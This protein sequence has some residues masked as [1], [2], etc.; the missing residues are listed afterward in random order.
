MGWE[1]G[2]ENDRGLSQAPKTEGLVIWTGKFE[3]RISKLETISKFKNLN[4]KIILNL[5]F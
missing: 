4:F 1:Y 2:A 3:A 5:V